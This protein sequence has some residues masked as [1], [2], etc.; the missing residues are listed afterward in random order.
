VIH[1]GRLVEV[2][3]ADAVFD[4][5]AHDYTRALLA[6]APKMEAR[7]LSY[8]PN[9]TAPHRESGGTTLAEIGPGHYAAR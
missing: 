6:A 3:P 2:G 8:V 9:V 1:R 5:P 4:A 7:R